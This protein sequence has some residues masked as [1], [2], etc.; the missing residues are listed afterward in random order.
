[1]AIEETT[2]LAAKL[3]LGHVRRGGGLRCLQDLR[4]D[5]HIIEAYSTATAIIEALR[6]TLHGFGVVDGPATLRHWFSVKASR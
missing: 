5:K 2:T 1:M 3:G 6:S 4:D